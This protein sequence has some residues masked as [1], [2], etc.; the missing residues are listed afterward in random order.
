MVVRQREQEPVNICGFCWQDFT[1]QRRFLSHLVEHFREGKTQGDWDENSAASWP[2]SLPESMADTS[3]QQ[4]FS[5]SGH[6]GSHGLDRHVLLAPAEHH[7]AW[8]ILTTGE[9]YA[10][11]GGSLSDYDFRPDETDPL[12]YARVLEISDEADAANDGPY[13]ITDND[14]PGHMFSPTE[15][16]G[17]AHGTNL[18]SASAH[19]PP[20]VPAMHSTLPRPSHIR[21]LPPALQNQLGTLRS[22]NCS[23]HPRGTNWSSDQPE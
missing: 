7:E 16:F 17:R 1:E 2:S 12:A 3:T 23:A 22:G 19:N 15:H 18:G 4:T 13:P 21:E 5:T 6:A 9:D 8:D 14:R 10:F 11:H 20:Y